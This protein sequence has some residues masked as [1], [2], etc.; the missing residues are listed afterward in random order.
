MKKV[1]RLGILFGIVALMLMMAVGSTAAEGEV[2]VEP[3]PEWA[4]LEFWPLD[5]PVQ[6]AE[7]QEVSASGTATR[8]DF[9]QS[10]DAALEGWYVV[11]EVDGPRVAAWYAYDG[12]QDSGWINDLS[13]TREAVHVRVLY[14]PPGSDESTAPTV[15]KILNH[16]PGKEYGWL[17]QGMEHALEVE[18]P[19]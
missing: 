6:G 17:A 13:I 19:D 18:F 11:Q 5:K 4:D 7:G 10:E 12:W 3:E 2:E 15:M 8:I 14:Y 16:A 9:E 1:L